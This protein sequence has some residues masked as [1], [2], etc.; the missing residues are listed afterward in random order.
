MKMKRLLSAAMA[1]TL[2]AS[3]TVSFDVQ[4]QA[5]ASN[6]NFN[7][8][9]LPIVKNPVTLR[10]MTSHPALAKKNFEEKDLYK[11]REKETNVKIVWE[12]IASSAMNEKLNLAINSGDTPDA[13]MNAGIPDMASAIESKIVI[14]L[15]DLIEK[16]A[17]N[18]K[19]LW[20][21]YPDI[22]IS[23]TYLGD[24]KVYAYAGVG[25]KP[26]AALRAPIYINQVWLDNLKLKMPTNLDEFYNVLKEFKTKDPNKNGKADEIPLSLMKDGGSVWKDFLTFWEIVDIKNVFHTMV[27]NGKLEFN[28]IKPGYKDA[29]IYFNKLFKDGLLDQEFLTQTAAQLQAKG[30]QAVNMIGVSTG[31]DISAVA[32]VKNSAEYGVLNPMK[33][34]YGNIL[35][36]YNPSELNFYNG[37]II[38]KSCKNPEVAI[39]WVDHLN[40][41]TNAIENMNGELGVGWQ[42]DEAKKQWWTLDLDLAA[43]GISLEDYRQTEAMQNG[44]QMAL[45]TEVTGYSNIFLPGTRDALKLQYSNEFKQYFNKEFWPVDRLPIFKSLPET[46]QINLLATDFNTYWDAFCADAI[47][48]GLDD[49]KWEAH[50]KKAKELQYEKVVAFYQNQYD[51]YLKMK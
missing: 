11:K 46:K 3:T 9:G 37:M 40:D 6:S 36:P 5:A 51:Q 41:G 21:A 10:I 18:Q 16:Y 17:P 1:L 19:L 43:K 14:P 33:G 4:T 27:V 23:R 25:V 39:R 49:A 38:F 42:K 34:A 31:Y 44:P 2:A 13:L 47:T 28:P 24:N 7:A 50:L 26:E 8:T 32:N 35:Y 20:K 48:K 15:D 30:S 22:K 45:V 29:L 12:E